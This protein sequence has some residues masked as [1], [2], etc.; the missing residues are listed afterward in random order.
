[1]KKIKFLLVA[2]SLALAAGTFAQETQSPAKRGLELSIGPEGAIPL[3]TFK[4]ESKYKFG[5]GGSAKLAIPVAKNIDA[6]L[7]AGYIAFSRSRID[8][9]RDKNTFTAIPFKAGLRVRANP[10]LYFEPQ[11]GYTQTKIS[12]LEGAGVFTY[13]ANV[14]FLISR[15]VDIAVRYEAMASREGQSIPGAVAEDISA[16]FIGIRLAYNIP[17]GGDKQ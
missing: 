15:A 17:F 1:M 14:G 9:V 5:L 8:E 16:K 12:N 10:G 6:T 13:A 2:F 7:S 4:S 11:V 3:G